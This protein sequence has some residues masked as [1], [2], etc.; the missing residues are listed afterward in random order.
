M[1]YYNYL[2]QPMPESPNP[3]DDSV[4]SLHGPAEGGA[5]L[6]TPT[7]GPAGVAANGGNNTIIASNVDNSYWIGTTDHVV[8]PD[9]SAG[10][11]TIYTW[12]P[13]TLPANVQNLTFY[14]SGNWGAGN[15]LDNLIVMGGNDA[16]VMDGGPGNDVLVGG[17]GQNYFQ[18]TAGNGNDVIYNFHVSQDLVRLPGTSFTSFAQVQTAMTQVGSDVVLQIDPSE[19]LTFRGVNVADFQAKNFLMPLDT[20][21][22]GAL[23][24]DDE[25]NTLQT[26]DYSTGTGHWI[27]NL[28][29]AADSPW[30]YQIQGNAEQQVYADP[31]FRGQADH[32]LGLNPFS[33]NN[34]V[35]TITAQKLTPELA[36]DSWGQQ[37]SSGMLSTKGVFMQ[38]YGYFEIGAQMPTGDGTWPAFWLSEDPY[39]KGAEADIMEHL[40]SFPN[41][42]FIRADDWSNGAALSAY[43]ENPGGFHDYGMLWTP[44]T[45]TFYIDNDAVLV[46]PTPQAWQQPMYMML[47]FAL[48]GWAGP[49]D[50]SAL[51][52]GLQVDYVRVYGLADNTQITDDMRPQ[53]P[54]GTLAATG[55]AI[56]LGDS[57]N[58]TDAKILDDGQMVLTSS[59]G[60]ADGGR[61]AQAAIYDTTTGAEQHAPIGLYGFA[62]SGQTM[63]PVITGMD[64]SFWRVDFAGPNAPGGWQVYD[65]QGNAVFFQNAFTDGNAGFTP[66]ANGSALLTNSARSNFAVY[67]SA[68]VF[69]V[70][71]LP[72]VNGVMTQPTEM[73]ALA[74]GGFFFTYAGQSQIDVF[75]ADGSVDTQSQLGAPTS[76]FAMASD[77]M[78]NGQ[79]AVA[80]L[81]PPADGSNVMNLTFQTFDS[82]GQSLAQSQIVAVDADPWHTELKVLA[83]G[84]DGEALMLWSQ[85]GAIH[86]AFAHGSVIDAPV[87]LMVGNLDDTH[88]TALTD[89]SFLLTWLQTDNG[90]Q[91]L[92]AKTINPHT[93]Q[94][95]T[96]ELGPADAQ[97]NVVALAHGAY[98]ISWH[99]GGQVEARAYDGV[100]HIGALTTVAGD[101]IGADASGDVVAL[102]HDASGA[103][104]MQH[105]AMTDY[106]SAAA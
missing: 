101:F 82:S 98:A 63:D 44:T 41:A 39:Q 96:E 14:G 58:W 67:D 32:D 13:M 104:F 38:K 75:N 80:W 92:W 69:H 83:T 54:S 27:T 84:Q 30:T 71:D 106:F 90:V 102:Y 23:T 19:T 85:G 64:G 78:T 49:V 26:L 12:A 34:G 42:N 11:K 3:P 24:F 45:T 29:G 60:P 88:Q 33:V 47:D 73:H 66:L 1:T 50:D 68:G 76:S 43:M 40:G 89:G 4:H 31:T 10:T 46:T 18:D 95:S 6:Y 51:P 87:A 81:A 62:S 65:G 37:Y 56:A 8:V 103:G 86:A 72:T 9:G 35:L 105:Y 74:G 48:G 16:N 5:T 21:K 94:G 99:S 17:F 52:A 2:G 61:T 57:T 22:L 70:H 100:G 77:A 97:G 55:S 79:F 36:S 53:Q 28:G 59:V 93:M 91:D 7:T 20:S 15:T 25:F